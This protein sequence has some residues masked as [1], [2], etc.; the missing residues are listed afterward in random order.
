MHEFKTVQYACS[1]PPD[2]LLCLK[3]FYKVLVASA[4]ISLLPAHLSLACSQCIPISLCVWIHMC[5]AATMGHHPP[6]LLALKGQPNIAKITNTWILFAQ[7][8]KCCL[9][10]FMA[11]LPQF[12]VVALL[13]SYNTAYVHNACTVTSM[14]LMSHAVTPCDTPVA[15]FGSVV[16]SK[17]KAEPATVPQT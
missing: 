6:T 3:K 8:R 11:G 17:P 16:E 15:R 4:R 10:L 2:S 1:L 5:F 9:P 12:V 14:L 7:T 13:V